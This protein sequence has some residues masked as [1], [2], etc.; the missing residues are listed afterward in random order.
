MRLVAS[1]IFLNICS[2]LSQRVRIA[3]TSKYGTKN[4]CNYSQHQLGGLTGCREDDST[5]MR[6]NNPVKT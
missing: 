1:L 5:G 6:L 2:N 4:V 3:L